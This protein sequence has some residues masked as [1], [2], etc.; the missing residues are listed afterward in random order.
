[1]IWFFLNGKDKL[2]DAAIADLGPQAATMGLDDRPADRQ[3]EPE[4]A[5]FRCMKR[6]EETLLH[7]FRDAWTAV[8]DR[9][10]DVPGAVEMC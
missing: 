8:F 3:A 1:M 2:E 4:A 9:D 5:R 7:F 6:F 10:A